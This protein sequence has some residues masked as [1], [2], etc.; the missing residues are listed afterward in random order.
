MECQ[1]QEED[2]GM[3][4]GCE[5]ECSKITENYSLRNI[6]INS[7]LIDEYYGITDTEIIVKVMGESQI[8]NLSEEEMDRKMSKCVNFV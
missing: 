8:F 3:S 6:R 7:R 4:M 5:E 1:K 2:L